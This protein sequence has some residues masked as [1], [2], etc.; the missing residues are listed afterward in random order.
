[1]GYELK[2]VVGRHHRL[3]VTPADAAKPEYAEFWEAMREGTGFAQGEFK[4]IAKGGRVVWLNATYTPIV[5]DDKV[6]KIV[7]YAQDITEEK[8]KKS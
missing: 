5:I 6:V 8:A 3:F 2:D 7:K 4:R 1:M